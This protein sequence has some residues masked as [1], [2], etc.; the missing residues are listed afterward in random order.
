MK[1]IGLHETAGADSTGRTVRNGTMRHVFAGREFQQSPG[2]GR[3]TSRV[4]RRS[5]N[6]GIAGR[7]VREA[8]L[9]GGTYV[10]ILA[11]LMIAFLA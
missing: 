4:R 11:V 2:M 7:L 8:D 6:H 5:R 1:T 3:I 9:I 10:A